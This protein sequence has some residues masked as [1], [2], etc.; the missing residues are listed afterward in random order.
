MD[1]WMGKCMDYVVYNLTFENCID[2][3]Q[4]FSLQH[5]THRNKNALNYWNMCILINLM[6]PFC[7]VIVPLCCER[8][9]WGCERWWWWCVGLWRIV[10]VCGVGKWWWFVKSRVEWNGSWKVKVVVVT[11]TG[12]GFGRIL[13]KRRYNYFSF[14]IL[15]ISFHFFCFY[16]FHLFIIFIYSYYFHSSYALY[17]FEWNYYKASVIV[18][19]TMF[20]KTFKSV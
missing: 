1:G 2:L 17:T 15:V 10:V 14:I 6:P 3:L 16:I 12:K 4:L 18:I 20:M 8:W 9:S 5:S 7:Y 19:H 11:R 13:L